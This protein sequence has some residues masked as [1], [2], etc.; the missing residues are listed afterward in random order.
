MYIIKTAFIHPFI[1]PFFHLANEEP[2]KCKVLFC[3]MGFKINK[4]WIRGSQPWCHIIITW[5]DVFK[6]MKASVN[7]QN[8]GE[9]SCMRVSVLKL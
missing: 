6:N 2:Q 7:M 9:G 8:E 5:G 3:A 1:H 4:I